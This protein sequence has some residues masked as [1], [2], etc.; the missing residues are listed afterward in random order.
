MPYPSHIVDANCGQNHIH[1]YFT[2]LVLHIPK[3]RSMYSPTH[4]RPL[5]RYSVAYSSVS[6]WQLRM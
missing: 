5:V 3:L 1:I 6:N 2:E 4:Q